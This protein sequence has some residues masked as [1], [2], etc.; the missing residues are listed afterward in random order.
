MIG[1]SVSKDFNEF[2]VKQT[3]FVFFRLP[4]SSK[5]KCYYQQDHTLHF[6]NNFKI[7][8]FVMGTFQNSNQTPFIPNTHSLEYDFTKLQVPYNDFYKTHI[9]ENKA[10]FLD[11]VNKTKTAINRGVLKKLVVARA[12]S[13]EEKVNPTSLFS[14]LLSL[15]PNAMVYYWYH[16]K[17]GSWVGASPESL[18][19]IDSGDFQTMA[20]AGTL[21]YKVDD[22]YNWGKKEKTEQRIVVDS[23][24][25]VLRGLFQEKEIKCSKTF[26]RRAGNLVHLCNIL[27]VKTDDFD[28]K[29]IID[30]LHPTPAVGGIPKNEGVKFL[31]KHEKFERSFYAGFFGP[32]SGSGKADLFVNL[33]CAQI[34]NDRFTLY[35]GAGITADSEAEEEWEETQKKAQTI[36][37]AIQFD[38]SH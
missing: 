20:L 27:S 37:R 1:V 29:Q 3:P 8:G 26:T 35:V 36:L 2:L 9:D 7:D 15:Y 11:L 34:E 19:S 32:I 5:I 6:T 13:F 33:R 25:S 31:S 24:L 30:Q 23:I 16:P 12:Q 17:L 38:E 28:L 14:N 4:N 18:F 21:P 10:S 22:D